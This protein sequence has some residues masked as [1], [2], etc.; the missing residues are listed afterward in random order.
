[1][2]ERGFDAEGV[3]SYVTPDNCHFL[4]EE[5][6]ILLAGVDNH[7][8]RKLLSD[9]CQ[10]LQKVVLISG[11]NELY[12]GSVQV[13][14]R[15]NGLSLT[16]PLDYCHPEIERPRDKGPFE[17]SCLDLWPSK[18]QLAETNLAIGLTMIEALED[19]L[20]GKPVAEIY[21]DTKPTFITRK[22]LPQER[23]W[24]AA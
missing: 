16:P 8:T 18:P 20:A 19:V 9:R 2:R 22:V 3:P 14:W 1:L 17:K 5:G 11:G 24:I 13:F 15:E 10:E 12:D 4:I 6:D 23:G 21:V 7:R